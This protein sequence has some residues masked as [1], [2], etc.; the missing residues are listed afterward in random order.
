M[1]SIVNWDKEDYT[2][3]PLFFGPDLS[4]QRY[5][6]FKYKKIF[7]NFKGQL[8]F[9][10]RPEEVTLGGK[11][12]NEFNSL[13]EHEKSIFTNNLKYQILLDSVVSRGAKYLAEHVSNPELEAAMTWWAAMETLHSYSYTYI[14]KDIYPN[15]GEV[16]D[17]IRDNPEI[18]KRSESVTKYYDDLINELP[19]ESEYDK[20][21]KLYLSLVS[22]NILEGIRFYVSFACSYAF[23]QNKKM[24]GNAKIISLINRDENIHLGLAQFLIKTLRTEE[25]EGFVQVAKD[26]EELVY[27]MYKDAAKE[28]QEWAEYLFSNGSMLGLNAEILTKYMKWLT[29]RRLR[30]IGL[31]H[32]FDNTSNPISWITNW[33][34]SGA[35]QEAPQET[36]KESYLI[37]TFKQDMGDADYSEFDIK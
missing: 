22:V 16:F 3:T 2:K 30:G 6:Q 26:C 12:R 4:I 9:F 29:N 37:G 27:N 19:E 25:S 36:E 18:V 24:E 15:P 1:K 20:K 32:I 5:D 10:W 35:I 34:E 28:E 17:T 14:I 33:T 13:T 7:N 8:G 11:E 31:K 21:K 23:A